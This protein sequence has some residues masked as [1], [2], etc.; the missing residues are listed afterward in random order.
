MKTE[1]ISRHP[2]RNTGGIDLD[3]V[4]GS[5]NEK[6]GLLLGK[7]ALASWLKEVY[8]V[9]MNEVLSARLLPDEAV[10]NYETRTLHILEKKFQQ[11]SGSV[12]E[13]L[14]TCA[15]KLRQY[16]RLLACA[17]AEIKVTYSYIFNDWFK[18]ERYR[19]VRA[20]MEESNV[21]G[22]FNKVPLVDLDFTSQQKISE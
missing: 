14:Q 3:V 1:K 9:K 15:F 6:L 19:D 12:D 20:Y 7:G 22:Y 13:K 16:K 2:K 17:D 18:H 21:K 8:D 11:T 4:Y 5:N 10:Y